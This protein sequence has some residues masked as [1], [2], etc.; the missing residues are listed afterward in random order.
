[1]GLCKFRNAT[2][3]SGSYVCKREAYRC[4]YVN[5]VTQL[6]NDYEGL[7]S[8]VIRRVLWMRLCRFIFIILLSVVAN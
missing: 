5:F 1:M 2:E 4:V 3:N 7:I 8:R 6:T